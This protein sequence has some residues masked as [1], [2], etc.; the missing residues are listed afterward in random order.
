MSST[1]PFVPAAAHWG[2]QA[3][4]HGRVDDPAETAASRAGGRGTA[5]PGQAFHWRPFLRRHLVALTMLV[6]ILAALVTLTAWAG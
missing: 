2:W 1:M 5:R 6:S 4:A 3:E